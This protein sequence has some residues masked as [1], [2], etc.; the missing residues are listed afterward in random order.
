MI[1]NNFFIKKN[2]CSKLSLHILLRTQSAGVVKLVDTPDS[3]SGEGD[4][5]SVR[6]RP[7]AP[8]IY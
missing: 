8:N 2:S 1:K 7:S 6:L 4:L 5:V 3:K